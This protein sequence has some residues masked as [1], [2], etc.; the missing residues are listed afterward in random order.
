MIETI[1]IGAGLTGLTIARQTKAL[2][3]EK[4][5]GVGG[6]IATRRIEDQRFDHGLPYWPCNL[7][8]KKI[9]EG[10]SCDLG[11]TSITKEMARGI[12][13]RLEERV[14]KIVQS[15]QGWMLQTD[16][17]IFESQNVVLTA[18]VPQALELLS[19]SGFEINPL[20]NVE[21]YKSL[22]GLYRLSIGPQEKSQE[23]DGH[24][25]VF[26]REKGMCPDGISLIASP[27]FSEKWFNRPDE[28]ILIEVTK[29]L[30][31]RLGQRTIRHQELKKWRYSMSKSVSTKPYL[32]VAPRLFLAG[33]GFL[34]SGVEGALSSA[35]TLLRE[36]F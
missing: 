12:D 19:A 16:K 8:A 20:W 28:E 7:K 10:S 14:L 36:K 30:T 31:K 27:E 6:R 33:D 9:H 25:I 21:Y 15:P 29:L 24:E 11:L 3:I 35:E 32:E 17:G 13:I 5:R 2:I 26:Q 34:Y 1:V 4:S 18:P 22:V 23:W